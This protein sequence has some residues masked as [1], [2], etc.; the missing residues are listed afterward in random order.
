MV[1]ITFYENGRFLKNIET[2][3]NPNILNVLDELNKSTKFSKQPTSK[4]DWYSE[5]LA[6]DTI[7]TDSY[8]KS[9]NGRLFLLN[10]VATNSILVFRYGLYEKKLR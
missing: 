5:E 8:K 6:L 1:R 2:T 3:K 4:F 7:I 10:V 9:Q